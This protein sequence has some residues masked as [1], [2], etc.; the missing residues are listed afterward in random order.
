MCE[1]LK[2]TALLPMLCF[3][4]GRGS[5]AA[6]GTGVKRRSGSRRSAVYR[7]A[8]VYGTPAVA[9]TICNLCLGHAYATEGSNPRLRPSSTLQAGLLLTRVEP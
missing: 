3:E 6:S 1:A 4:R 5:L 7:S 8:M 2:L 9:L